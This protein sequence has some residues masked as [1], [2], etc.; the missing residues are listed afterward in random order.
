MQAETAQK[1]VD[2]ADLR[3]YRE[4]MQR[5]RA[6]Y[7]IP[8]NFFIDDPTGIIREVHE[9]E[10]LA[11]AATAGIPGMDMHDKLR[12]AAEERRKEGEALRKEGEE[13]R[14]AAM[15]DADAKRA[16]GRLQMDVARAR[17]ENMRA[18]A[19]ERAAKSIREAGMPTGLKMGETSDF[20][21]LIRASMRRGPA[22]GVGRNG[23]S[24]PGVSMPSGSKHQLEERVRKAKDKV[25]EAEDALAE[26]LEDPDL[27]QE[28]NV[29]TDAPGRGDRRG[30]RK[31]RRRQSLEDARKERGESVG[32]ELG[33]PEAVPPGSVAPT[34]SESRED[35]PQPRSGKRDRAADPK[36]KGSK[37]TDEKED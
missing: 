22:G 37:S 14:K 23:I 12:K 30:R 15:K 7:D 6:T 35:A 8:G 17:G 4:L 21:E 31:E 34:S 25:I 29:V 10:D 24:Q 33:D 5:L 2:G 9:I 19:E 11:Q 26:K 36:D 16:K 3:A 27:D 13:Q 28:P 32:A 1:T 18:D 20:D